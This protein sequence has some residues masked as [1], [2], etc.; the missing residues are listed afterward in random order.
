MRKC[1]PRSEALCVIAEPAQLLA[2]LK[3]MG[4]EGATVRFER[5]GRRETRAGAGR[6]GRQGGGR[7]RPDRADEGVQERRRD[8]GA[9]AAHLRDGAAMARFLAWFATRG[10]EGGKL[11]EIAAAQALET[12]RRETGKLKDVSLPDRSPAR[13]RMAPSCIIA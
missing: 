3:R 5:D 1:A 7:R 12:F 8:R 4:E 9:R 10:A 2:D 13:G 6:R 11:T